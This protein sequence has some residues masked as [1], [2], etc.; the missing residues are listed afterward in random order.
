MN[1]KIKKII[2][3]LCLAVLIIALGFVWL[4]PNKKAEVVSGNRE[5]PTTILENREKKSLP[6]L[7][8]DSAKTI[9]QKVE[10]TIK[11]EA[12]P[13]IKSIVQPNSTD[14]VL[15]SLQDEIQN[16]ST[17]AVGGDTAGGGVETSFSSSTLSS[18]NG[19]SS[20]DIGNT[21]TLNMNENSNLINSDIQ[22]ALTITLPDE[23]S[24]DDS[25]A[26]VSE[27]SA[28]PSEKSKKILAYIVA[29]GKDIVNS[30]PTYDPK[31]GANDGVIYINDKNGNSVED[32]LIR[33]NLNINTT[34]FL[35]PSIAMADSVQSNFLFN[36]PADTFDCPGCK[37]VSAETINLFYQDY[38]KVEDFLGPRF[39]NL[40]H[41]SMQKILVYQ[42][43]QFERSCF[44]PA[45]NMIVL[46]A[47]DQKFEPAVVHELT[48]A[49][50]G[51][52]TIRPSFWEEGT[53]MTVT[54]ELLHPHDYN[55]FFSF[56]F[57]ETLN[58]LPF[59]NYFLNTSYVDPYWTGFTFFEKVIMAD[60]SFFKKFNAN[61]LSKISSANP[62]LT[63]AQNSYL[64]ILS[65]SG[66]I[67]GKQPSRWFA[68]RYAFWS[69]ENLPAYRPI[70][71]RPIENILLDNPTSC[72]NC[73]HF[74]VARHPLISSYSINLTDIYG[75]SL[76]TIT[77]E[78][79]KR[80]DLYSEMA[81]DVF[82]QLYKTNAYRGYKGL[83]KIAILSN[84]TQAIKY[85]Y[86]AKTT[87]F[88]IKY[89][90]YGLVPFIT[91]GQ[92]TIS[93]S[94]GHIAQTEIK[95][96]LFVV[97]DCVFNKAGTYSVTVTGNGKT[98]T[99]TFSKINMLGY[100]AIIG[101]PRVNGEF[102]SD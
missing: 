38:P 83:V 25:V 12:L 47:D 8:L 13:K 91:D 5:A 2:L 37:F 102:T 92:A 29:S 96:G 88:T 35:K 32:A 86:F 73:E 21:E 24:I 58:N 76:G 42:S 64:A 68:E 31:F 4:M 9:G 33:K 93:N 46:S 81:Y 36:L 87:D 89:A 80:T 69:P 85:Q 99:S 53:A 17:Q 7:V 61:L 95:N 66:N 20:A 34:S 67:E 65:V 97:D 1:S 72:T 48:H 90:I 26:A 27:A 28:Q 63:N 82:D 45:L 49:F 23:Y 39:K 41:P 59:R 40:Y 75:R 77:P 74:F 19:N 62:R 70:Y 78:Y 10:N 101:S 15:V 56:T 14:S 79:R 100:T 52:A 11:N 30:L 43:D 94:G 6:E 3:I 51:V 44:F 54:Y 16:N 84:D 57:A 22:S 50:R 71:Y 55:Y 60:R 18:L 98:F